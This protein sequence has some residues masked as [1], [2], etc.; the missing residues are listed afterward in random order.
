MGADIY[1]SMASGVS[2]A[3]VVVCFMSQKY[4]DSENCMLVRRLPA[5]SL[6]RPFPA[7]SPAVR[8]SVH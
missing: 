2:N 8:R 4:Q 5:L 3:V 6:F 1:E 7:F